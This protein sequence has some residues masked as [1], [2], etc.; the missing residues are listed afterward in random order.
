MSDLLTVIIP[1]YNNGKYLQQCIESVMSQTYR[2]I[3]VIVVDD[4]SNDDS[5]YILDALCAEYSNL[6]VVYQSRNGGVSVARNVGIKCAS[7]KY[8]TTLDSDDFYINKCKLENEM[9]LAVSESCL[10][11]SKI[12]RVDENGVRTRLQFLENERYLEGD[13]RCQSMLCKNMNTIPRDY[14]VPKSLYDEIGLYNP[15][16]KLYE[17]LDV[18]IRLLT[19]VEAKCTFEEGTAYRQVQGGLS[20]RPTLYKIRFRWNLCWRNRKK[21]QPRERWILLWGLLWL[22]AEQEVKSMIKGLL[23]HEKNA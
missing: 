18:L 4:C 17:D 1:N 10:A 5:K 7:G 16:M 21:V 8:L 13:I 3:E 11:Y 20:S 14:I 2:P 15:E 22:R 19:K 9:H 12:V 6:Y 23:S